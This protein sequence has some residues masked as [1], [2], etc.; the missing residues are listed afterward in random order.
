[1]RRHHENRISF[2][3][4]R[5]GK[6]NQFTFLTK[7][8]PSRSN[9]KA[10]TLPPHLLRKFRAS[11]GERRGQGNVLASIKTALTVIALEN[12]DKL[13]S[14]LGGSKGEFPLPLEVNEPTGSV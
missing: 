2:D 1:M 12:L 10:V 8:I 13:D 5:D 7:T 14:P 4:P 6:Q 3:F 11:L 9:R